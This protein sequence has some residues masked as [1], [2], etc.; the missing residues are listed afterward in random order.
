[1]E[2]LVLNI[3]ALALSGLTAGVA[4]LVLR[5]IDGVARDV[6]DIS[7]KVGEHA[8]K[9]AD[10][11]ARIEQLRREV[12]GLLEREREQVRRLGTVR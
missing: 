9:L 12:D 3:I 5:R 2:P 1:M 7:E 4:G 6:R 10:G 8:E 11:H